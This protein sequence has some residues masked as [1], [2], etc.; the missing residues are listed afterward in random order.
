MRKKIQNEQERTVKCVQVK[1]RT[2]KNVKNISKFKRCTEEN[3][4]YYYDCKNNG[5]FRLLDCRDFANRLISGYSLATGVMIAVFVIVLFYLGNLSIFKCIAFGILG[6]VAFDMLCTF[7]EWC[8]SKIRENT[9]YNKL[10]RMEKKCKKLEKEQNTTKEM[11]ERVNNPYYNDIKNAR[12]GLYGLKKL[13]EKFDFGK[14]NSSISKCVNSLIAIFEEL[15]NNP[16]S[17]QKVAFLYEVQLPEFYNVLNSYA[18][19]FKRKS[20]ISKHGEILEKYVLKFLQIVENKKDEISGNE[21]ENTLSHDTKG[22]I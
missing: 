20:V 8:I 5:V 16:Q 11:N 18:V 2:F 21:A 3:C 22:E 6:I 15:R 10:V 9:L 19:F 14:S 7:F 1:G 17:Y 4:K 13:S 12:V